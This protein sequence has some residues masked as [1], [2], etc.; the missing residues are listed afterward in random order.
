MIS[1]GDC[2]DMTAVDWGPERV[3]HL[4][5]GSIRLWPSL[6]A[7]WQSQWLATDVW[8][9]CRTDGMAGPQEGQTDQAY[10]QH[11]RHWSFD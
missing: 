5:F 3:I 4:A 1:K 8:M 9:A 11:K 7:D 10:T 6:S 2:G